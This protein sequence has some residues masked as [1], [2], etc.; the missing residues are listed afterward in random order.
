MKLR[1][2]EPELE[3]LSR[4]AVFVLNIK[5]TS[6][7]TIAIPALRCSNFLTSHRHNVLNDSDEHQDVRGI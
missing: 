6:N 3:G 5:Q 7:C 2:I 1:L 4:L